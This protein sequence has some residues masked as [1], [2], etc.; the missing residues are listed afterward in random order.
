MSIKSL[1]FGKS[2]EKKTNFEKTPLKDLDWKVLEGLLE[3]NINQEQF[4][5]TAAAV[6]TIDNTLIKRK[7]QH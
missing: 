5:V 3:A 7:I 6:K 2:E 1:V 4:K